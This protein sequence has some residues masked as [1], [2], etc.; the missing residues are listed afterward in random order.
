MDETRVYANGLSNGAG[1]S[2]LLACGLSERIAAIGLVAGA[3]LWPWTE[4]KPKRPV[5]AIIFHGTVDPLVPFHGGPSPLIEIPFPDVPQ[6]VRSLA[7]RN[8]CQLNPMPLPANG[9]ASVLCYRGG[10]GNADVLFYTMA[11]GGHSWPGGKAI[12]AFLVGKT[13]PDLDA[14]RLMWGF[15]K[16]HPMTD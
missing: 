13:I 1:M 6:W 10:A 11:G 12:P 7:E 15:F 9:A 16:E 14:T 3:Y 4:Y 8:G 2:F 5:P